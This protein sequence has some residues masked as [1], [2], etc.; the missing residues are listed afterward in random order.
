MGTAETRAK[1]KFNKK[2]Y[3]RLAVFVPKGDREIIKA[4]AKSRG[5]STNEYIIRL[6][7]REL[8]KHPRF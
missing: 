3:D 7:Y 1:N 6:I 2:N 5:L 8:G 4:A